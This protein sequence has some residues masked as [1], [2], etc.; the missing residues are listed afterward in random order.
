MA[1]LERSAI[2]LELY[3]SLRAEMVEQIKETYNI[4]K[5]AAGGV[6]ASSV[7]LLTSGMC[8]EGSIRVIAWCVPL[9]ISVLGCIRSVGIW[10]RMKSISEYLSMR[11]SDMQ[12]QYS[13]SGWEH[14]LRRS[15]SSSGNAS[16]TSVGGPV[17]AP[18]LA[19]H[20][21]LIVSVVLW[22]LLVGG[23]GFLA[24]SYIHGTAAVCAS[25][26]ALDV[27]AAL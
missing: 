16:G 5:L 22:V 20:F 15:G 18:W 10:V 21:P 23:S 13:V 25:S 17:H 26:A 27:R 4:E 2:E 7:W 6:L 14:Y 3:K 1:L 8:L 11:E 24:L 19:A 9:A 12:N